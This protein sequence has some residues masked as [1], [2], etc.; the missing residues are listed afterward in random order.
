M[1]K[2]LK[3]LNSTRGILQESGVS[4]LNNSKIWKQSANTKPNFRL[5]Y[6]EKKT[7][8]YYLTS[9]TRILIV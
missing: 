4:L 9:V 1:K 7:L 8:N 2:C 5:I 3:N 6:Q